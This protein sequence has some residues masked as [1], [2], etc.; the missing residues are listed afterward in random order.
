M[1]F[2]RAGALTPACCTAVLASAAAVRV[3]QA[4]H[5]S[6]LVCVYHTGPPYVLPR[7]DLMPANP[8]LY[9]STTSST[10]VFLWG[11]KAPANTHNSTFASCEKHR[12]TRWPQLHLKRWLRYSYGHYSPA[13]PPRSTPV[14]LAQRFSVPVDAAS[15]TVARF[16]VRIF[17]CPVHPSEAHYNARTYTHHP[18][19][20]PLFVHLSL[21]IKPAAM[22]NTAEM[23]PI[24]QLPTGLCSAVPV[25]ELNRFFR[26]NG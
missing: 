22:A 5:L 3:P 1:T 20:A 2:V 4:C 11:K 7:R 13:A 24:C 14:R 18:A 16:H 9:F 8:A 19:S 6:I 21:L 17:R 25:G 15:A 26:E 10:Y 12:E 23:P